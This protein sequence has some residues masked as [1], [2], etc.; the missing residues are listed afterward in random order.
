AIII[1]DYVNEW[2]KEYKRKLKEEIDKLAGNDLL[3]IPE[4]GAGDN[5]K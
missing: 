3:D 2:K 4:L 5:F 1:L